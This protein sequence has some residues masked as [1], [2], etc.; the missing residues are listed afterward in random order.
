MIAASAVGYGKSAMLFHMVR[1]EIGEAAFDE[2]LRDLWR[3]HAGRTAS[4][5]DLQAAFERRAGRPLGALFTPM[6][7]GTGAPS[8]VA[9]SIRAHAAG[10]VLQVT[11]AEPM[12]YSF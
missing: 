2:A 3:S 5:Q 10:G 4:W 11:F 9:Q 8:L 12:P 7:T 1:A 6:V